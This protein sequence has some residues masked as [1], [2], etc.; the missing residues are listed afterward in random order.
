MTFLLCKIV[1]GSV[2]VENSRKSELLCFHPIYLKFGVGGNFVML[3]TNRRPKLKLENVLSKE[4]YKFLPI[5][6]KIISNTLQQ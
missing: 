2:R 4:S 1:L 3:I 5:L 6:A